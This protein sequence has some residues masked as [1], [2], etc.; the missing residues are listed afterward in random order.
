VG[1]LKS[2]KK[3]TLLINSNKALKDSKTPENKS[4]IL[5]I[6]IAI[7]SVYTIIAFKGSKAEQY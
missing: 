5:T 7:N 2:I 3:A 6:K 1:G 4:L